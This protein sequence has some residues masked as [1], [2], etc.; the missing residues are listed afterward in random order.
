MVKISKLFLIVLCTLFISLITNNQIFTQ[1]P[2]EKL[3][4]TIP[5]INGYVD[6]YSLKYDSKSGA[7]AYNAY[8]TVT[9]KYS[10]I[11]PQGTSAQYYFI[12]QYNS[13]FDDLGNVYTA[14][15]SQLNDTAYAYYILKNSEVIS[16]AYDFL[17]EGWAEKDGI[18]YYS[19]GEGGKAYF[20]Q[21][22]TR[23]GTVT[24]SRPYDEIRLLYVPV[25]YAEGEP[26]G[27][28]GFTKSG[29]PYYAAGENNEVFL[30]IG[31]Q[32]QKHYSD[33]SSYGMKLDDNDVPAYIA[34]DIGKLYE[35][36]GNTFVVYGTREYKKYDWIYGPILFDNTGSA[37]YV[38]L[39]S[40]GEYKYRST[41]MQGDTPLKSV[42]GNIYTY[43]VSPSGKLSYIST[44]DEVNS[45]GEN[46][47]YSVI[48]YDGK[49]SKKLYSVGEI[50]FNQSGTLIYSASDNKGKSVVIKGSGIITEKFDY[51]ASFGYLP[52]GKF[53][54]AGTNY[55]DYEKKISDK[56]YVF[57]DDEMFGPYDV[58]NTIDWT[59][60]QMIVG[61]AAGN[62]AY[63]AGR[64]ADRE[65][66]YFRYKVY[67]NKWESKEY[68]N[69]FDLKMHNGKVIYFAGNQ[70]TRGIYI[71]NM[72]LFINNKR[73]GE[74]YSSV[75][76]IKISGAGVL[77]FM[78]S[79]GD[80]VY[81]VEVKL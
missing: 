20:N 79:K 6:A 66:Y 14:A 74:A 69:V 58:V 42:D 39:D 37:L 22:D 30:V 13:I 55:G 73:V 5:Q 24:K 15:S 36:R 64:N 1:T 33:I 34:K 21:L 10:L 48:T 35:E 52:N 3:I 72:H 67:T 4:T 59:T 9:Q 68:D 41:M 61:D 62:Y 46:A 80:G 23:T 16:P 11:T 32:E 17:A 71:Y 51:I 60:N 75:T 25:D 76:D 63:V 44:I 57:V 19:A 53:A 40:V 81:L 56:N 28:V 47:S 49:D 2:T 50:K 77:T 78:G 45:S 12:M 18:I 31:S 7:W 29:M 54:Y 38:G 70:I 43:Q 26:V 27:Y 8:D 65:N